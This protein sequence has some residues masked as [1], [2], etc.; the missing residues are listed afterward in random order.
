MLVGHRYG[1]CHACECL[2]I[3]V[4]AHD[5]DDDTNNDDIADVHGCDGDG[6]ESHSAAC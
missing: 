1:R 2:A 3:V 4:V 5:E 6:D